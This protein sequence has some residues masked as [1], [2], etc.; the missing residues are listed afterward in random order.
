MGTANTFALHGYVCILWS[1]FLPDLNK[2]I[3]LADPLLHCAENSKHIF[4]ETKLRGLV[5]NFYIHVPGSD[6]YIP[7]IG[8]IWNLYFPVVRERTLGST[9]ERRVGQVTATKQRLV[10]PAVEPRV[11]INDQ[12][13]VQISNLENY[14]S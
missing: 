10:A 3:G 14:G 8:L 2:I 9:E 4:P 6:F 12:L 7:M 5:P 11:H 13:T 1:F